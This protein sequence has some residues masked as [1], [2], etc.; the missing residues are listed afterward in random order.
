MKYWGESSLTTD[1]RTLA[2]I[3]EGRRRVETSHIIQQMS[4]YHSGGEIG[5]RTN[6]RFDTVA[7]H[8]SA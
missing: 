1:E 4:E 8:K 5:L 6:F 2:H 7:S 3:D